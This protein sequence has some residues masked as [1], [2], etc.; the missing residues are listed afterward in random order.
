MGLAS[1]QQVRYVWDS[2]AVLQ[3]APRS[4]QQTG[5]A[6]EQEYDSGDGGQ[7]GGSVALVLGA[8]LAAQQ[9]VDRQAGIGLASNLRVGDVA[10]V[11][12]P[13]DLRVT[14]NCK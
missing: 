9:L 14:G 2:S 11:A 10:K 6:K 4:G 7:G 3:T 12:G 13:H 5:Q 8:N 1:Q